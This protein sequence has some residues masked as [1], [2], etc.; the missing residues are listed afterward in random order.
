MTSPYDVIIKPVL[1]EKSYEMIP[2]KRY[3]FVVH[4]D[5][6]K[7]EI[8][9]AVE[10][11]FKGVKVDRVNTVQRLGK[12]KRYGQYLGRRPSTK[13]AYV[14]LKAGSKTIEFFEGMAQ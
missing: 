2:G 6:N 12:M 4:P 14:T 3:T 7:T 11:I 1:S 13:K 8:R 9:Q 5:A 10:A